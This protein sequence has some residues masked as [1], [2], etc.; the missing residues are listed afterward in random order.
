MSTETLGIRLFANKLKWVILGCMS[1]ILKPE[2]FMNEFQKKYTIRALEPS[3]ILQLVEAFQKASW[4]KPA[5]LFT[6]Y[7]R[8]RV[9]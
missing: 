3:D 6:R 2:N 4:P 8:G 9:E 7:A 5:S 1:L